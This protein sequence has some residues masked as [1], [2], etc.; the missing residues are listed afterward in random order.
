MKK[1]RTH[2]DNLQIKENASTEVI[3]GAYRYL[4]QRWHP[5]KNPDNR[6]E[7]ERIF[8]IINQA[9]AVLSDPEKRERHDE[10]IAR[11]RSGDDIQK[12]TTS[13]V[14]STSYQNQS[15]SFSSTTRTGLFSSFLGYP[16]IDPSGRSRELFK[17]VGRQTM[18]M[19]F[20]GDYQRALKHSQKFI[21][22]VAEKYGIFHADI[23][24]ANLLAASMMT[25]TG[26]YELA[27]Q[28]CEVALKALVRNRA[29]AAADLEAAEYLHNG[30]LKHINGEKCTGEGNYL[31]AKE[32]LIG[33]WLWQ[34]HDS[35]DQTDTS[36]H[37]LWND[38]SSDS[39]SLAAFY[40]PMWF[41]VVLIF[42]FLI[43]SGQ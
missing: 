26:Q 37:N 33:S 36:N 14:T 38:E 20:R 22:M 7:A 9:Y 29:V 32:T 16:D 8:R 39:T 18:T 27:L 34:F 17:K 41:F 25:I 10:W 23:G 28:T 35:H 11:E 4:S 13:P 15:D 6:Q 21:N 19:F 3:K 42:L 5:D 40:L 43:F 31:I 30:L 12:P 24:R 1:L 2:Y